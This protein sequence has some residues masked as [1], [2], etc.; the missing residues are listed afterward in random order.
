MIELNIKLDVIHQEIHL[1]IEVEAVEQDLTTIIYGTV[2]MMISQC[3]IWFIFVLFR[4]F[5]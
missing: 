5:A 4:F 1:K 3:K 2:M